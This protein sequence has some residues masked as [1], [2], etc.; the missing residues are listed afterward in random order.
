MSE[1]I[2]PP[3]DPDCDLRDF[4]FMPLDV[5][6]LRDST[7]AASA[8][9]A[10]FRC[11]VM[12][13][14]ASWHQ[15]PAGSLPNDDRVLCLLS[16]IGRGEIALTEWLKHR[17]GALS[18]FVEATDG[19]LY[20]LTIVAKAK[21]AWSRKKA[22]AAQ[23]RGTSERVARWRDRKENQDVKPGNGDVTVTVTDRKHERNALD[24][25]RDRERERDKGKSERDKSLSPSTPSSP[26]VTSPYSASF[27][28]WWKVYPNPVGKKAAFRAYE[29]AVKAIRSTGEASP[30]DALFAA[31]Q[32]ALAV[33]KGKD[34]RF[35]P[36]PTTWLNQGRWDDPPE[37]PS[38]R[39][40]AGPS[41]FGVGG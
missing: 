26:T 8:T 37:A 1:R 14:C 34:D 3:I 12:L 36:H 23:R 31:L 13:W 41:Q 21:E 27:E 11:A 22:S 40:P 17:D 5:V 4:P 18:G 28:R 15:V 30:H 19:R 39:G 9:D 33:W 29:R 10:E 25:D 35:I 24:R 20:H 7:L 32:A 38:K 2:S 16:G 6:R